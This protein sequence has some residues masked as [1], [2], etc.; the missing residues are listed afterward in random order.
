[1]LM[2]KTREFDWFIHRRLGIILEPHWSNNDRHCSAARFTTV[3][4]SPKN[5]GRTEGAHTHIL[6]K[7]KLEMKCKQIKI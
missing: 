7:K 4:Q 5:S 1:M 6:V 2:Y 3:Q